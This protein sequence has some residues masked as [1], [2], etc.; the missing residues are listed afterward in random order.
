MSRTAT[1]V[2]SAIEQEPGVGLLLVAGPLLAHPPDRNDDRNLTTG[3]CQSGLRGFLLVLCRDFGCRVPR[4]PLIF[5]PLA[6]INR[7]AIGPTRVTITACRR[8]PPAAWSRWTAR[9]PLSIGGTMAKRFK[10]R[11]G[12]SSAAP[13]HRYWRSSS[14]RVGGCCP[15]SAGVGGVLAPWAI[16]LQAELDKAE[17]QRWFICAPQNPGL[18]IRCSRSLESARC[19]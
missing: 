7:E 11:L 16:G 3:H 14:C 8:P 1:S 17:A 6:P 9:I 15:R 12:H 13:R 10:L 5:A 2:A 18:L 4:I 19:R